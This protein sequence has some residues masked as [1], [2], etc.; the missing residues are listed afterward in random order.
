MHRLIR[1]TL[2]LAVVFPALLLFSHAAGPA[3]KI[4][5]PGG[6]RKL[7]LFAKDPV[8]WKIIKEGGSGNML[9]RKS[10]GVFSLTASGLI[11]RSS[12]ALVRYSDTPPSAEII[13]RGKSDGLGRLALSGTWHNWTRKF[14]VVSGEDVVGNVG[15][16]GSLRAW[17]PHRYL[18]EAKQ[19]GVPCACPEPEEQ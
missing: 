15:E 8:T 18:F 7:I 17:R 6:N 1:T 11:P 14:W 19:L 16:T 3:S 13:A 5:A 10:T 9:Y 4:P 12:Y 2:V